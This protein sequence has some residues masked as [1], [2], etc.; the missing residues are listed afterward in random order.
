VKEKVQK[1]NIGWLTV[2]LLIL[3]LVFSM[4]DMVFASSSGDH[5][6]SPTRKMVVFQNQ[7]VDQVEK[8][9]ILKQAGVSKVKDLPLINAAVVLTDPGGEK[10]LQQRLEVL[11]ASYSYP[12]GLGIKT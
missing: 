9:Q 1:R 7:L 10:A 8:D 4:T 3:A 6:N 11:R 12:E 5:P 2:S